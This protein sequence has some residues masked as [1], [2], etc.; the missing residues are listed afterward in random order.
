M[1]V[2]VEGSEKVVVFEWGLF[3]SG[4]KLSREGEKMLSRIGRQLSPRAKTISITVVG[5]TDNMPVSGKKEYKDNQALGLTRAAAALRVL[6]SS[7]G[8]PAAAFKTFSHGAEW[9]PF[10]ND[11][12]ENRARN[13]TVVLRISGL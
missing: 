7:S 1:V 12:A 10:P 13:R 11:T 6:Q 4:A 3:A 9:S 8:I 2:T 5:C